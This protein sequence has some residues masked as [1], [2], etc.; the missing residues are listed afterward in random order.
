MANN[1]T[2]YAEGKETLEA[3]Q[4]QP[5]EAQ[6]TILDMLHRAIAISD[7]YVQKQAGTLSNRRPSA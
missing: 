3:I 7:M 6:R 2:L 5:V 4:R 1:K